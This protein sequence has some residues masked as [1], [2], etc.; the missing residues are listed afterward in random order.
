MVG[1]LTEDCRKLM[2]ECV[3]ECLANN[4]LAV[5]SHWQQQYRSH[6]TA[7][8]YILDQLGKFMATMAFCLEKLLFYTIQC[9]KT[10]S[11]ACAASSS[12]LE[13]YISVHF[14][15]AGS[16]TFA[17]KIMGSH[18]ILHNVDQMESLVEAFQE[19]NSACSPLKEG[20][21]K[22]KRGC[23]VSLIF[24]KYSLYLHNRFNF[25]QIV[26]IKWLWNL[27]ESK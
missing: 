11:F 6:F 20:L 9:L 21:V 7:S 26:N 10:M 16:K 13:L 12:W 8:A 18:E 24:F 17:K 5:A 19:Y 25:H 14:Y 23:K 2:T 1:G 15:P 4:P 27:D 3:A 22:A